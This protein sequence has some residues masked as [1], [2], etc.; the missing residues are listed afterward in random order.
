[1]NTPPIRQLNYA[2]H[3][4]CPN[5]TGV[6]LLSISYRRTER[7]IWPRFAAGTAP[8][9]SLKSC[10][11][12]P[13]NHVNVRKNGTSRQTDRQTDKRTGRPKFY[14]FRYDAANVIMCTGKNNSFFSRIFRGICV[15]QIA[16]TTA[17]LLLLLIVSCQSVDSQSTT[18]DEE[19]CHGGNVLTKM[20]TDIARML[21]NQQ[22][23]FQIL[24]NQHRL[25]Q[26]VSNRLGKFQFRTTY[27]CVKSSRHT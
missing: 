1:M 15:R 27:F 8:S 24:N 22:Q 7:T 17:W 12:R 26:T 19:T 23:L 16:M 11:I 3:Y 14:I 21:N 4:F 6:G 2:Q 5:I 13:N 10:I 25:F 20:Q 9:Q 18:D